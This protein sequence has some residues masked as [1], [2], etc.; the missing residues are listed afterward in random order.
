MKPT[1]RIAAVVLLL[2]AAVA[3]AWWLWPRGEDAEPFLTASGT[4]EA[5]D[6]TLGF[7]IPGRITEVGP[8]EGDLVAA[9]QRLATLASRELEAQ[10]SQAAAR[11]A[12]AEARLRLL[13]AGFRPEEVAQGRAAAT[14]AR[15]RLADAER[16]LERTRTLHAGGAV[17]QEAL[18]K[19][20]LAGELAAADAEQAAERLSLLES[21]ARREE[22]DAAAAEAQSA[23]ATHAAAEA[24]LADTVLEAPRAGFVQ[25]RHRDPGEVVPAGAPVLTLQDLSDRWVRIYV[26]EDRLGAV[27]LGAA[28]RVRSD[29]FPDRTYPGEVVFLST[30]AEFTPENVQTQEERVRLVYAVKVR[31]T[32][33]PDRELKPGMP[34]DVEVA[35]PA[36]ER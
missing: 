17:P 24:R 22:V 31:I 12:A 29:T 10:V 25:V 2:L 4:V 23:R 16:D 20:T 28:A 7:E 6:A 21:G 36:E 9:G 30:E 15:R 14:A 8:R 11:V 33:D 27:H 32:G 1:R 19:A 5:S 18:D 35:L 3:A 26:P 13:E 34:V